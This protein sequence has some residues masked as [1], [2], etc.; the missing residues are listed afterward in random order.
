MRPAGGTRTKIPGLGFKLSITLGL[1]SAMAPLSTDLHLPGLPDLARTLDTSN[2]LASATISV[3]LAGLALGQLFIGSLSDRIGRRRPLLA[4]LVLFSLTGALCAIA[5]NIWFLL[6]M[7]FVQGLAGGGSVVIARTSVRDH[8]TGVRAAKIF[9]QV[10]IIFLIAPVLAPVIGG[11][12]LRFTDWRGLFWVFTAITAGQLALGYFVMKES[13]P[14]ERRL[15]AGSSQLKTL[16]M[17]IRRK[18]FGQHLVMSACQG[19]ILFSYITMSPAFLRDS[20]DVGAQA[21]SAIFAANACGMVVGNVI[22]SRLVTRIG[23]LNMLTTS[24]CGY[25]VATSLLMVDVLLRAPLPFVLAPLW[26]VL[27]T[28]SPS[29]PNNMAIAVTPMGDAAGT[30]TAILGGVQQLSGAVVPILVSLAFG[31]SG[32]VMALTMWGAAIIGIFQLFTVLRPALGGAR[33]RE[34][35]SAE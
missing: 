30:A 12:V 24:V 16:G 18:G 2:A 4:C 25:I 5:P 13:L 14:R 35:A 19:T 23:A 21:Y 15:P 6:V 32:R 11:Q 29:N 34:T 20:Y 3:N 26:L 27:T 10:S 22:S 9:S 28:F 33:R 31:T 1:L 7:R 8:A 17:V